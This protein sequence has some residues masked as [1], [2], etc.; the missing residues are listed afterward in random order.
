[1]YVSRSSLRNKVK[2]LLLQFPIVGLM[3]LRQSGK[4]TL[5]KSLV[6][7]PHVDGPV[8]YFDLEYPPDLKAFKNPTELLEPLKGLV[9][10]DECQR[11]P[12]LFPL[13]RVLADRKPLPARFVILGSVAGALLEQASESLAGRVAVVKVQ[14]FTTDEIDSVEHT[15][16]WV[17]GGLPRAFL[18][19]DEM[20]SFKWREQFI[21]SILERDLP[22]LGS[23]IPASQ[24]W[25]FW[26]M[27]AHY[28]GQVWK[29]S[30]ISR[31]LNINQRTIQHYLDLLTDA[32]LVR[33]L[34]PYFV[35]VGK[36]VVKSPKFYV[37]DSGLLHTLLGLKDQSAIMR[38]PKLGASWEGFALEN[39]LAHY[40]HTPQAF[41]WSTYSGGEVDLVIQDD[42]QPI[43]FEFKHADAPTLTKS[44]VSAVETLNLRQLNIIYPGKRAYPL[45]PKVKAVPLTEFRDFV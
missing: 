27:A 8:H 5:A 1:M 45:F 10:I 15:Q 33:Q 13:L 36:R 21:Q 30:E 38:H 43:G 44:M 11:K 22:I 14:G 12:D 39:V 23:R 24:L 42:A 3:G 31:S 41:F 40:E 28:H 20:V 29:H 34:P 25:R 26:Q 35:N 19:S 6:D 37:R 18:A 4:T 16:L 7:D 2:G 32:M 17:R 9:I